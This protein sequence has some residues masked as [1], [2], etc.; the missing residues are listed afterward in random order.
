MDYL[1][2]A[3]ESAQTLLYL[4]NDLLDF[5][6]TDAG[7]FELESLPFRVRSTLDESMRS[8]S[9]RAHEKGLEL[10]CRI[11]SNVPD[12]LEGDAR[13]FQQIVMNLCGN[14]IKFTDSGGV[15]V[16]VSVA[17]VHDDAVNL[18]LVVVDTGIGIS[19][20]DQ[21]RI[22]APFTQADASSTRKYSGTGLGLAIARELATRMNGRL[23]VESELGRGSC[24]CCMLRFK[25]PDSQVV[26]DDA[27]AGAAVADKQVLVVDHNPS[28]RKLLEESAQGLWHVA[29]ALRQ[30]GRGTLG[31][32]RLPS[33]A[34]RRGAR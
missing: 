12:V 18:L 14:A 6:G 3:H 25:R 17:A 20:I 4:L 30:C 29:H 22:F 23:W 21:E 1:G 2:T 32:A 34:F 33:G 11:R 7:A 24:F 8:L 10:A 16:E 28:D 9:L 26:D 19:A 5:S 27:E 31:T 13:R 15:I